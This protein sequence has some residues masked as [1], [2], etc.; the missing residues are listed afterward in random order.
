[1]V[2]ILC[3]FFFQ[4]EDGIRDWSV[5]GV[6]TCALPISAAR[7]GRSRGDC[8]RR[9]PGARTE[10][11]ARSVLQERDAHNLRGSF[12]HGLLTAV[13]FQFME[14]TFA[15]ARSFSRKGKWTIKT[16][17]NGPEFEV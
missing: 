2:R 14:D 13:Y 9:A 1:M 8:A 11:P 5:T 3:L 12:L 17:P 10:L 16:D 6:Q 15:S 7:E 4:A